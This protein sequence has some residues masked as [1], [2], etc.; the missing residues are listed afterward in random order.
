MKWKDARLHKPTSNHYDRY[1]VLFEH[2]GSVMQGF[3][4]WAPKNA[5]TDGD[6]ENVECTNGN[7]LGGTVLFWHPF[8]TKPEDIEI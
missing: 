3:A 2:C 7:G 6:W 1:A 5:Y 4:S 8:L